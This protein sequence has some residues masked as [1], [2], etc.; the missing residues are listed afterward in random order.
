MLLRSVI[1]GVLKYLDTDEYEL[2]TVSSVDC[3]TRKSYK[4]S[5]TN[6][7]CFSKQTAEASDWE[8]K[9]RLRRRENYDIV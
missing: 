2:S 1:S 9:F 4:P 8:I 3:W 7:V 6:I 5:I